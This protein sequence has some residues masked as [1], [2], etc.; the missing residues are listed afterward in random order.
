MTATVNFLVIDKTAMT[1]SFER[2]GGCA[3]Q[4]LFEAQR[5][6]WKLATQER[7]LR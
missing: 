3:L 1:E 5:G 7:A 4:V 6:S 2:D